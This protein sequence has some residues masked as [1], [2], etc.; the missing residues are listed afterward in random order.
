MGSEQFHL[1]NEHLNEFRNN[2]AEHISEFS[3][4]SAHLDLISI[5]STKMDN[6]A[7]HSTD[8][9]ERETIS[10][11]D[12]V[13]YIVRQTSCLRI[14]SGSDNDQ[15]ASVLQFFKNDESSSSSDIYQFSSPS[16]PGSPGSNTE[17]LH[18]IAC[19][20]IFSSMPVTD[21]LPRYTEPVCQYSNHLAQEVSGTTVTSRDIPRGPIFC[22]ISMCN[23]VTIQSDFCNHVTIDHPYIT[24]KTIQTNQIVNFQINFKGDKTDFARCQLV[25]LISGKIK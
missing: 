23:A 9:D 21:T 20:S 25:F 12:N 11:S 6:N 5:K 10:N 13:E 16:T 15:A 19:R 18:T 22:P 3:M 2:Q 4:N 7:T 1:I 14:D 17:L 8:N 24:F